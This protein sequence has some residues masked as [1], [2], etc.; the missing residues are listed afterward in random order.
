[1]T[2]VRRWN[3][4][5][6]KKITLFIKNHQKEGLLWREIINYRRWLLNQRYHDQKTRAL[7]LNKI[8]IQ[9]LS[10]SKSLYTVQ[11]RWGCYIL[12]P[13]WEGHLVGVRRA[14]LTCEWC[15]HAHVWSWRDRLSSL[16]ILQA[17]LL[18]RI[19]LVL[20]SVGYEMI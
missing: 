12:N 10:P 20:P 14:I 7:A 8:Q 1:M 17:F 3:I 9:L 2:T 6:Y 15:W 5:F 16:N 4:S 13:Q 18:H 19:Y 11:R